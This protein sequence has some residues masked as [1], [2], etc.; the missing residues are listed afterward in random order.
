[1]PETAVD[2]YCN[3]IFRQNNIGASVQIASVQAK[4][5]TPAMEQRTDESLWFSILAFDA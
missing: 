1:M 3:P 2:K 5:K 4:S